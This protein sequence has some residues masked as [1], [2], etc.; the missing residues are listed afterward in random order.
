M[1]GRAA[2]NLPPRRAY[3]TAPLAERLKE[4]NT[5]QDIPGMAEACGNLAQRDPRP[6]SIVGRRIL[7]GPP[8]TYQV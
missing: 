1:S 4:A 2:D 5:A 8:S 7:T 6:Y 3:A